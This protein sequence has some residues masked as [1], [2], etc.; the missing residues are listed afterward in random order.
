[1]APP[2]SEDAGAQDARDL[3][4]A[5]DELYA[6]PPAQFVSTRDDHVKQAKES[7]RKALAAQ[8]GKLRR[9]TQ[10]AWLV[11]LLW[12]S[13]PDTVQELLAL[14]DD[15]REAQAA[16]EGARLRQLSEVR[17]RL[18]DSLLGEARRLAAETD[19]RLD[20][21]SEREVSETLEAAV[22]D[23]EVADLI[24]SGRLVKPTAYAGFGAFAGGP[25]EPFAPRPPAE[26]RRARV[27]DAEP[28]KGQAKPKAGE[29]RRTERAKA[30]QE[31][32]ERIVAAARDAVT[33]AEEDLGA[34]EHALQ[35]ASRRNDDLL[36]ELDHLR[37]QVDALEKRLAEGSREL[38]KTRAD[39][40]K[41]EVAL[42]RAQRRLAR[43]EAEL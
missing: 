35:D 3:E 28:K 27:V 38:R 2:E 24:R 22:L 33:E 30:K 29:D 39:R 5:A 40:A 7:G 9:P 10:A 11:N 12:R 16:G 4:K 8:L 36:A 41:A 37:E 26:P 19:T 20:A 17:R 32:A 14:G 23:P 1:M 6:V 31:E 42:E 21:T 25:A 43:A 34:S 18:V 13:T 15:L